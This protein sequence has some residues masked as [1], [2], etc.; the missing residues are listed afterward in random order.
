M[1][2]EKKVVS[3]HFTLTNGQ[4]E[5]LESTK[6][7][8]AF[9]YLHGEMEILPALEKSLEGKKIGDKEV[10]TIKSDDAYGARNDELLEIVDIKEF[11]DFPGEIKAGAEIEMET[12]EGIFPVY[13]SKVEENTVT[14]DMNHP[15]AG[16]DLI[17]D[18]E[19][20]DL[21]DATAEELEHGHVHHGECDH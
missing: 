12:E 13:I 5:E 16:M 10:I 18:V 2:A 11:N 20:T 7:E 3:M 8:E 21:R 4:G 9:E 19:I 14:V 1:I 17:F 15:L 6:G